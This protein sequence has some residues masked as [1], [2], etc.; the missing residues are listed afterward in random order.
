MKLID[1]DKYNRWSPRTTI[2]SAVVQAV[3]TG[4]FLGL[5]LIEA[6]AGRDVLTWTFSLAMGFSS[7]VGALTS[8]LI[9]LHK[10][11]PSTS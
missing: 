5:A 11:S 9:A 1:Y 4:F 7:G 10:C 8:T 6:V 2:V 3:V